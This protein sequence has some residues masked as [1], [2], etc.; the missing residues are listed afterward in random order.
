MS[1]D[2]FIQ[3]IQTR[4]KNDLA[5]LDK[6]LNDKKSEIDSQKKSAVKEL[7]ENYENEAKT[8]AERE[9]A[10]I[11]EAGKL[12][13]K[14]I[15]FD[16]INKNLDSTFDVIKKELDGY[17][18]KPEYQTVLQK[19]V[20]YSKKVLAKE[21]VVRCREEDKSFFGDGVE[22]TSTIQ[23]L[24]GFVAENKEGTKELDLTFE[25]L[26]RNNE[27]EIKNTILEKIL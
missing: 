9:G 23:S 24:G 6:K 7:K 17:S 25:E 2:T 4:K 3:E 18:K 19:L 21:I 5:E 1:V 16:A 26:L 8:K 11:I 22:V 15:L 13:A 27:D 14:K 20:D 10:R 12:E